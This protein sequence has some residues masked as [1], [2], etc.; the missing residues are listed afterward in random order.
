MIKRFLRSLVYVVCI[1]ATILVYLAVNA[2][3]G[4]AMTSPPLIDT[5]GMILVIALIWLIGSVITRRFLE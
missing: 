2:L 5:L 1:V 4:I 3:P